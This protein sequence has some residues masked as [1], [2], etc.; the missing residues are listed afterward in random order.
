MASITHFQIPAEDIQRAKKFYQDLF[1][2]KIEKV[3]GD[4]QYYFIETTD[5]DGTMGVGG[6]IKQRETLDEQITNFIGVSSIDEY[7]P[8]I[9]ALGGKILQPKSPVVGWGYFII[10]CDTENNIFGLWEDDKNAT[11]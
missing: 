7:V 4:L 8:K 11:M 6:G 10:C 2:W 5:A 3:P 1:G 9:I